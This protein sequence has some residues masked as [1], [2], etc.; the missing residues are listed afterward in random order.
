MLKSAEMRAI[1][2]DYSSDYW[3]EGR[4]R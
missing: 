2:R 4:M 3:T 1:W